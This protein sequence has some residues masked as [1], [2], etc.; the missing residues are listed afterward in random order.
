MPVTT[1]THVGGLLQ[2][3]NQ[4]RAL[5]GCG[6]EDAEVPS[7]RRQV[8]RQPCISHTQS[9]GGGG[10]AVAGSLVSYA[11]S[12]NAGESFLRSDLPNMVDGRM[13]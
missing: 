2:F 5:R 9:G 12:S 1:T 3:L 6:L 7:S 11:R 4:G 10:S 8:R 13:V